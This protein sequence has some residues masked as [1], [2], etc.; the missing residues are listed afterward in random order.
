MTT[1]C[2]ARVRPLV[3]GPTGCVVTTIVWAT[4][5]IIICEKLNGL[6]PF[7]AITIIF[8]PDVCNNVFT[9]GLNVI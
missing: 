8:E 3:V 1:G 4:P 5:G 6:Y 7:A 2:V 9:D